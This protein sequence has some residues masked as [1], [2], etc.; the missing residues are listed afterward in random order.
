MI[1][2]AL[3]RNTRN[4]RII[5]N[6]RNTRDTRNTRHMKDTGYRKCGKPYR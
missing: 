5:R 4:T 1:L 3:A 6:T 2:M